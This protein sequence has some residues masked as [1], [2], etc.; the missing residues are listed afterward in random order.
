MSL[1]SDGDIE[2]FVNELRNIFGGR[3][4]DVFLYGSYATDEY[5]PG[6]DVDILVLFEDEPVYEDRKTAEELVADYFMDK[7]ILFSP[8]LMQKD[9]FIQKKNKGYSFHNEVAE[10][11]VEI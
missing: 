11:G 2:E 9:K 7:D 3:I 10:Q 4:E 5:V 6:S 1:A 8:K